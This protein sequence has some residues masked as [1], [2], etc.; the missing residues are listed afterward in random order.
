MTAAQHLNPFHV[1]RVV[2]TTALPASACAERLKADFAPFWAFWATK[3]QLKGRAGEERF[4]CSRWLGPRKALPSEARGSFVAGGLGTRAE[5][6]IGWRR[7]DLIGL[8]LA[9]LFLVVFSA[10][11]ATDT[12]VRIG[13]GWMAAIFLGV[14]LLVLVLHRMATFHDDEFLVERLKQLLDATEIPEAS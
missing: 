9:L 6:S 13:S 7:V 2:L 10:V 14:F 8:T 5:V 12:S 4:S 11:L 1:R 3:Q